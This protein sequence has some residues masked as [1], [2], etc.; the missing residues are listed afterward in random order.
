[1]AGLFPSPAASIEGES[2][3]FAN[4]VHDDLLTQLAQLE[5]LRVISRTSVLEYLDSSRNIREIGAA[6]GAD[7]ILE[8]GV[9]S[10]AGRIRI[11]AQLIDAGTDEHVWAQTYD[12]ELTAVNIFEVQTEIAR[13]IASAMHT[14][15]TPQDVNQLAVI[16]TENMAA[17]R[18]FRRALEIGAAQGI[19]K[20][21]E[22]RQALQQAVELDPMFTRAMAEL[23]GYLSFENFFHEE[24]PELVPKA[25]Q[26]LERIRVLAANSA[27]Y[28]IAQ[29]YYTYYT[30]KDFTR[31]YELIMRAEGMRPSDIRLLQVKTWIQRRLGDLEGRA[32]SFRKL[33]QLDPRSPGPI[34]SLVDDLIVSHRYDEARFVIDASGFD[35]YAL[36]YWSNMLDLREH[37]N[38]S[39]W[40]E[41]LEAIQKDHESGGFFWGDTD[42]SRLLDLWNAQIANQDFMR[43][44]QLLA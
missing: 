3:F 44:E 17:Y 39:R 29:S 10:A 13:A 23:V 43:A 42:T 28:L 7:A 36:A 4:G 41:D 5:S 32:E 14:T 9:Q 22:Y 33:S 37:R 35:V 30:L 6:L 2:E 24:D 8:G 12:R 20:N 25:E 34:I 38:I 21:E 16:P 40:A 19:W 31:A 26:L 1:M 18:A 15:L 27:D 11:N